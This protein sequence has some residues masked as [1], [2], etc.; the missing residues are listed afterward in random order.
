MA[1]IVQVEENVV[2]IGMENGTLM[3][4]RTCDL[5]FVP[6]VGDEV[7]VFQSETKL[8]VSKTV[9]EQQSPTGAININVNNSNNNQPAQYIVSDKKAVNKV[10]YCLLAFFLGGIGIHKFYAGKTGKGILYAVFFWTTIP[11]IISFF[12]FLG[13]LFKKADANGMI[14]V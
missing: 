10:A 5:N 3:E 7:E 13:A 6:Q 9:K 1:K 14:L 2:N 12:E 8:I 4:V 11:A